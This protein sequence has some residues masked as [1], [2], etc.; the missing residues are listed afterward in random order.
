MKA[1]VKTECG[2]DKL[3][4][5]YVP[6]PEPGPSDALIRVRAVG[7]CG[8]DV[9][10]LHDRFPT[11]P[12][13]IIGHEF[14]GEIVGL[15]NEVKLWSLGDRVVAENIT[16]AC[17][18]CELCRTGKSH[19][20][21]SKRAYGS[22]SNGAMSEYAVFPAH[23]LHAVPNEV[24][25]EEAALV[26]P[27][28]VVNHGVIERGQVTLE[29]IVVVLGPGPIG[30]LAVQVAKAAGASAVLLSGTDR[31]A[32]LR[33]RLGLEI[34]AD[35]VVN[36]DR[37]DL[38]T[39]VDEWTN[40]RGADLVV[41]AA[42]SPRAIQDAVRIV[43]RSKRIISIGLV[44]AQVSVDWDLAV[45]KEVTV[46]FSKSSTYLS[47]KRALSMIKEKKVDVGKL[48]THRFPIEEWR[49]ALRMAETG[50]AVKCL[51]LP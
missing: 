37:Q 28:A 10:I 17:G 15:G 5:L 36:V 18:D 48:I 49:E 34:G 51:I 27:L 8:T 30:L 46:L 33:L 7:V 1:V 47:W 9:D 21:P 13:L 12:P 38:V 22:E 4:L 35:Q 16:H 26:E 41:E 31:D 44:G 2:K 20:C 39:V 43:G 23:M 11:K 29:D 6:D 32:D 45:V 19:I 40:G 3:A 14:S 25:F 50:E 42:G 24:S